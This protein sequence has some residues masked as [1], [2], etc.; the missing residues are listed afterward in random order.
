MIRKSV[1]AVDFFFRRSFD[2]SNSLSRNFGKVRSVLIAKNGNQRIVCNSI[3][4]AGTHLLERVFLECTNLEHSGYF[5]SAVQRG[6]VERSY[7]DYKSTLGRIKSG[8]FSGAHMPYTE[9]NARVLESNGIKQ[10]LL[11]RDPKDIL[12]SRYHH[13]L[14]RPT[15]RAH[16]KIKACRTR[17]DAFKLLING[18]SVTGKDGGVL[19]PVPA[20]VDDY[21]SYLDWSNGDVHIVKFEDLVGQQGGGSGESQLEAVKSLLMYC[22][23]DFLLNDE[24]DLS[25]LLFDRNSKTFRRGKIFGW[26]DVL[27]SN[28]LAYIN[29]AFFG[30]GA[31]YGYS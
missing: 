8:Y 20:F 24:I 14:S 11:I 3:P 29:E 30:L 18:I 19:P 5:F 1:D 10:V 17:L 25:T 16:A 13:T 6:K 28:E 27:E 4:K 21:R 2:T 15:N 31:E 23:V 9:D 22:E 12:I 7:V 26:K